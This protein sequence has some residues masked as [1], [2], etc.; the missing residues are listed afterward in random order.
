MNDDTTSSGRSARFFDDAQ[1][2]TIEAAM[3]RIIPTDDR[4]GAREAGTIDFLERY[5]SGIE[6]VYARPD[7]SGFETL[8]GRRAEAWRLRIEAMR[9]KYREGIDALNGLS[10]DRFGNDFAAL[11]EREQDAILTEMEKPALAAERA[12]EAANAVAGFA[13]PE[14]GLQQIAAEMD[15]DFF[16]LLV[17]HTRQGFLSDPVY[18]GNRNRAAWEAIGF[19][20]PTSMA[21]VHSG[22]YSTLP[23]FAE[24]SARTNE[25]EGA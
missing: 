2:Q 3:A 14:P 16:P 12:T 4:P 1:R 11:A 7:G 18:G 5:L 17:L 24:S 8:A 20:G 22:S 6:F 25:E 13:P 23:Y 15:L 19:P 9:Q 21:E 10:R